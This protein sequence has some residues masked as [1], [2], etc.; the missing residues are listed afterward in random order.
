MLTFGI[1]SWFSDLTLIYL[2]TVPFFEI[3]IT[4]YF[5]KL[6]NRWLYAEVAWGSFHFGFHT[7]K[8]FIL[9]SNRIAFFEFQNMHTR[10]KVKSKSIEC[11]NFLDQFAETPRLALDSNEED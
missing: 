6:N 11:H 10:R 4:L 8:T 9:S 1:F 7:K 3:I 2:I 5:S